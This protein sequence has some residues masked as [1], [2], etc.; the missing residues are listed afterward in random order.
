MYTLHTAFALTK[1]LGNGW[2]QVDLS[3]K[4]IADIR[5]EFDEVHLHVQHEHLSGIRRMDFSEITNRTSNYSQTIAQFFANNGNAT[6]P[7]STELASLKTGVVVFRDAFQAGY[8]I[9]PINRIYGTRNIHNRENATDAWLTKPQVD[10]YHFAKNC[11]VAINGFFHIVDADAD[12]I[13]VKDAYTTCIHAG[14]NEVGIVNLEG[15]SSFECMPITESMVHS[16]DEQTPIG[17]KLYLKIPE[18]KKDKLVGLVA[19]GYLYLLDQ[20]SFYRTSDTTFCFEIRNVA[21]LDRFFASEHVLDLSSL[22][23]ER[24]G[25][26]NAQLSRQELFSEEVLKRYMTL[27][28]SF[29]VFFDNPYITKE[30]LI[31]QTDTFPGMYTCTDA[32]NLPLFHRKGELG[33][34]WRM[35]DTDMWEMRVKDNQYPNYLHHTTPD[36]LVPNP[37]DNCVPHNTVRLSHAYFLKLSS[38]TLVFGQS[39]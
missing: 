27:S 23:L 35:Q 18:S 9:E 7:T 39:A 38:S 33:V 29:L 20:E 34:Y 3:Q 21:L 15:V 12:G 4:T 26:N 6:I 8:A 22:E 37:A 31:V 14:R 28:Q 2:Q 16:G 13:Y 30:R 32:P 1:G 36:S 5:S 10:Y 25:R 17:D 24:A 11:L 19:G